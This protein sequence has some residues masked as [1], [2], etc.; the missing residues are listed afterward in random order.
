MNTLEILG[1]LEYYA[2]NDPKKLSAI[3]WNDVYRCMEAEVNC[4]RDIYTSQTYERVIDS[5]REIA[6]EL[7]IASVFDNLYAIKNSIASYKGMLKILPVGFEDSPFAEKANFSN[8]AYDHYR[9]NSTVVIGDSHVIFFSGVDGVYYLSMGRGINH[10]PQQNS[11]NLSTIYV[12]S[13]LAYN[14]MKNNSSVGFYEKF[15]FLKENFIKTGARIMF[16]MGEI[17]IRCHVFKEAVKQDRDYHL[18]VDDI[19]EKYRVFMNGL[20]EEGYSIYC[21][22]PIGTQKDYV[23]QD[24]AHPRYGSEKERNTAALYYSDKLSEI[25]KNEGAVFLSIFDKLVDDNMETRTEYL[26]SDNFHI[27]PK[28][29]EIVQPILNSVG[30]E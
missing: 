5:I 19:L 18:I 16:S 1:Q 23:K 13:C 2:D 11:L 3:D 24:P 21:W 28:A 6:A 22:G 25:C 10:C 20:I 14:C 7:E 4:V 27:G 30:I 29:M 12:G 26:C 9:N 17:D 8:A 15:K